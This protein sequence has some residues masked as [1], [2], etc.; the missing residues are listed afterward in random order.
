MKSIESTVW[1]I[2]LKV[3]EL[4]EETTR[5]FQNAKNDVTETAAQLA[6]LSQTGARLSVVATSYRLHA[7]KAAFLPRGMARRR[8]ER[9]HAKN[10]RRLREVAESH[11]GAFLKVGQLLS[12]R[13]DILP[14]V[15]VDELAALQDA[16]PRV[17]FEIIRA[18]LERAIGAGFETWFETFDEEPIAAASMG[19]VHRATTR[20]GRDVAVKILRPGIGALVEQDLVLLGL[21]IDALAPMFPPT[22]HATIVSEIRSSVLRELDFEQEADAARE[23][24]AFLADHA[25]VQVPEVLASFSTPEVLTTR[26]VA[27][28]K[29]T[30]VL[31]ELAVRIEAGDAEGARR[32]DEILGTLLEI[33]M[34]QILE[35]GHFHSDPHPGNVLVT[36]DGDVVLLDFGS[37]QRL[38]REIRREYL[39]LV[40]AFT[41]GDVD[42][43]VRSLAALGFR[44]RSGRPETLLCFAEGLI[45]SFAS[46]AREARFPTKDELETKARAM[47]AAAESDPVEVIPPEFVMIARVIGTLAGLFSHY[48]PSVDIPSRVLPSLARGMAS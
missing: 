25:R 41:L 10:A 18:V 27:G 37:T 47:F 14:K 26:F 19:Q 28:R 40:F 4:S 16:A 35:A 15:F 29:I 20:E 34:R 45:G 23:I 33:F 3:E 30:D 2:R 24:S 31:D 12:A 13:P 8:L 43:A 39:A 38:S 21:F 46:S 9:L 7:T 5:G 1:E 22:D 44:T 32:R 17:P 11:G 36:D 42:S 6:R 48:R